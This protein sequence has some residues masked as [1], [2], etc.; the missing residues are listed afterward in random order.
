VV[1]YKNPPS[2]LQRELLWDRRTFRLSTVASR[3]TYKIYF[4][5]KKLLSLEKRMLLSRDGSVGSWVKN[6]RIKI[7]FFNS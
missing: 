1:K 3:Q 4:F 6:V 7:S 5:G 2:R